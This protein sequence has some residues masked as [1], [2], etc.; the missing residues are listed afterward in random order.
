MVDGSQTAGTLPIDF[1]QLGIDLFTAPGHKGLLGPQGTGFLYVRPGLE[2]TP[3]VYGGTG[4]NSHSDL[5][6]EEL[7]ERLECGT[8]NAPGIA[9]LRAAVD[10]LLEVGLEEVARHERALTE[11][12]VVGLSAI[13][14]V[15]VY[16]HPKIELRGAAIS[17]N[18][19]GVDPSEVG[20]ALDQEYGISVR[21]GLHCAPDA[22][23][24][25]GT[26]PIGTVRV[27]PGY[28]TQETDIDRFLSAV[29]ELAQ[30]QGAGNA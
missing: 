16:G 30:Q 5:P 13:D 19:Q 14:G 8:L 3:L 1:Q 25:I 20:F 4:G 23:R 22:H 26:Y 6:P 15:T 17:F 12:L 2:L 21:V 9:G 24:T 27:S 18:L 7:P 28:F 29:T 10:F 11:R